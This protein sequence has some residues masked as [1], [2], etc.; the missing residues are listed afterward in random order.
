MWGEACWYFV[1]TVLRIVIY[2]V[3]ITACG[4]MW[5]D[6][7]CDLLLPH[8]TCVWTSP[9]HTV[10]HYYSNSHI[11]HYYSNSHSKALLFE[12]TQ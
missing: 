7:M 3:T 4:V 11:K 5:C 1:M 10:K 12:F 8:V 6:V 9:Q 2:I